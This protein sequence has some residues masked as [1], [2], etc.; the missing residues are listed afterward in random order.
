VE[1][2]LEGFVIGRVAL[3][4]RRRVRLVRRAEAQ[5]VPAAFGRQGELLVPR[6]LLLGVEVG[7]LVLELDQ[8]VLAEV[9]GVGP[10]GEPW[11]VVRELVGATDGVLEPR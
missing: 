10:A 5:L 4:G 3:V 2:V 11:V 7:V 8:R 9:V 1:L 6:G